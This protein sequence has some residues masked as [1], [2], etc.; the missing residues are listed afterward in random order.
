VPRKSKA[1]K[2]ELTLAN[3]GTRGTNTEASVRER[4][5]KDHRSKDFTETRKLLAEVLSCFCV[6]EVVVELLSCMQKLCM[7]LL[8]V[9]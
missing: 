1:E 5:S 6:S 9:T 4:M 3:L 2:T 8:D 7:P